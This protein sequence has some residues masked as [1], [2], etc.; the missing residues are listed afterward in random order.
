MPAYIFAAEFLFIILII[1]NVVSNGGYLVLFVVSRKV[2]KAVSIFMISLAI[3]DMTFAIF[4]I[5]FHFDHVISGV[6]RHGLIGCK[7]RTFAYVIAASASILSSCCV[8]MERYIRIIFPMRHNA[9]KNAKG[10]SV[11]VTML[12]LY[13]LGSSAFVFADFF[14]CSNVPLTGVCSHFFPIKLFL[15]LFVLSYCIPL[16]LMFAFYAHICKITRR[17]HRQIS[18]ANAANLSHVNGNAATRRAKTLSIV[19]FLL[20]VFVVCWLPVS[21]FSLIIKV[22]YDSEMAWPQWTRQL[23]PFLNA[24]AFSNS[25]LS[26][27]IYGYSN[28]HLKS[29]LKNYISKRRSSKVYPLSTRSIPGIIFRATQIEQ[30]RTTCLV[31]RA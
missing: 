26:P 16:T 21:V 25:V 30:E 15:T 10:A 29:V 24:V 23:Y 9:I 11:V 1:S 27:L 13:S 8:T 4:V 12:W 3:A 14:D 5:P 31:K 7:L 18:L 19:C 22:R 2:R 20:C 6:W 17:H 28:R